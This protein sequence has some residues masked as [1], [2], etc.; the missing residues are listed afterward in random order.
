MTSA[1]LRP[2]LGAEETCG[3]ALFGM[4]S[5]PGRVFQTRL[6][7]FPAVDFAGDPT[8]IFVHMTCA[9]T[10]MTYFLIVRRGFEL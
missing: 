2:S 9:V 8:A 10:G 5:V 3:T 1:S 6:R 4:H 7:R